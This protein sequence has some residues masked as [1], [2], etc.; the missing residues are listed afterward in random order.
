MTDRRNHLR[1]KGSDFGKP[2]RLSEQ[3]RG[4]TAVRDSHLVQGL[5]VAFVLGAAMFAVL[6]IAWGRY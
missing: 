5:V 1:A 4:V 3:R 2:L 6:W